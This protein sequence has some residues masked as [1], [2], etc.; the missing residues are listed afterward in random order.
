MKQH[1]VVYHSYSQLLPDL[2]V[3]RFSFLPPLLSHG[4]S[5]RHASRDEEHSSDDDHTKAHHDCC[6]ILAQKGKKRLIFGF[7]SSDVCAE[8]LCRAVCD[9]TKRLL[10]RAKLGVYFLNPTSHARARIRAGAEEWGWDCRHRLQCKGKGSN[11]LR[12]VHSPERVC[13]ESREAMMESSVSFDLCRGYKR[14]A[15]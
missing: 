5:D 4:D 3:L 2:G 6:A 13:R 8:C 12:D 15:L 14:F 1:K 7:R 11:T 10:S 9:V